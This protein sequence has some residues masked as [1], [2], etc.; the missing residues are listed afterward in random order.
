MQ[1]RQQHLLHG[2]RLVPGAWPTVEESSSSRHHRHLSSSQQQEQQQHRQQP[3]GQV[4][5]VSIKQDQRLQAGEAK[6]KAAG[7]A[8]HHLSGQRAVHTEAMP[9]TLQENY[10]KVNEEIIQNFFYSNYLHTQITLSIETALQY[11]L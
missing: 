11:L 10:L 7:R 9:K 4:Y 8:L 2:H 6:A 3:F 5:C 1:M